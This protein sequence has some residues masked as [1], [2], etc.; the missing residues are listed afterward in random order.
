MQQRGKQQPIQIKTAEETAAA[1]RVEAT[2]EE[3]TAAA[4]QVEATKETATAI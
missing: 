2:E 3:K 1:I 4:I